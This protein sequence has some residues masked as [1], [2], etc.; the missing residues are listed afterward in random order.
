NS[1]PQKDVMEWVTR[2]FYSFN[3]IIQALNN[4][5]EKLMDN[6]KLEEFQP[7]RTY[8]KVFIV[9]GGPNAKAHHRAVKEYLQIRGD[10]QCIIH[11]S[12]KNAA[13]YQQLDLDQYFCLVG[14][15]GHRLESVF[16]NLGH[17]KGQCV[18]PPFPRKMGTYIPAAVSTNCYEL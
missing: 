11:A 12:S 6:Q 9:G 7:K 18:L 17:F 4:Q 13:Y 2:R 10:D 3:S 14:N 5:R 1:L 8:K 16:Q 15:E